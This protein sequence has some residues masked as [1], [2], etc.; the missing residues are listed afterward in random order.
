MYKYWFLLLLL[1][2]D[3]LCD[4]VVFNFEDNSFDDFTNHT[5]ICRDL[6][7]WDLGRYDDLK[8]DSPHE[9]STLYISPKSQLSCVTS[10]LFPIRAGG[11][12]EVNLYLE[13]NTHFD[14]IFVLVYRTMPNANDV[15]VAI[16]TLSA[17]DFSLTRGWQT[18]RVSPFGF[19]V[20]NGYVTF[21][22]IASE[23]SVILIDSV[24]FI[25]P[26][27]SE[28]SCP[29]YKQDKED[30]T[31]TTTISTIVPE[32]PSTIVAE[33]TSNIVLA[34]TTTFIPETVPTIVP[35]TTSTIMP[36]T[37]S[38][39][40]PNDISTNSPKTTTDITTTASPETTKVATSTSG[41][42]STTET[43]SKTTL[44]T[45]TENFPHTTSTSSPDT[46]SE[47][48][49][50][51]TTENDPETCSTTTQCNVD[52]TDVRVNVNINVK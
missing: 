45:T 2:R 26:S 32:T 25:A 7:M 40:Y 14:F 44:D 19:G 9:N 8:M 13:L 46:T 10:L 20:Y 5:Q 31:N 28:E 21:M 42:D 34:S 4:C 29:I 6:P 12:L 47:T 35:E 23:S 52:K 11:T 41:P 51:T 1:C 30:D 39:K 18:V 43:S 27:L 22:G 38:D 3:V 50:Q 16:V 24:R 33:T 17:A 49:L 37:P 48:S 36:E 15:V